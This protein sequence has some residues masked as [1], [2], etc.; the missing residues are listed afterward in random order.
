MEVFVN[1]ANKISRSTSKVG[2]T[3]LL[4]LLDPGERP[5]L[6]P[7]FDRKNWLHIPVEDVLDSG[8]RNAPTRE[9]VERI[10]DWGKTL[11]QDA[12]VLV[13]CFAG[14]SRSTAAALV[15]LVQHHGVDKI[16]HCIDLLLKV[17]PQACPNG[18]ITLHGDDLLGCGGELFKKSE[19]VANQKIL[20][21]LGGSL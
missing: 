13:A 2:V 20:K 9:I 17:R 4:T 12:V 3:H 5:F 11:P 1:Q 16:D 15:L 21:L 7:H 14:V 19:E 8:G 6:H 18:L 10:L